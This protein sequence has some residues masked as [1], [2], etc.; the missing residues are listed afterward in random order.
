MKSTTP[1][2]VDDRYRV[3]E[4]GKAEIVDGELAWTRCSNSR[5]LSLTRGRGS[6]STVLRMPRA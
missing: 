5:C 4:H 2:T 1:A 3:P 6:Q